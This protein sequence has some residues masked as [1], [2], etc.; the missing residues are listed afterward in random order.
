LIPIEEKKKKKK[1]LAW[2]KSSNRHWGGLEEDDR[3]RV[4]VVADAY[5][6]DDRSRTWLREKGFKYLIAINPTRFKE[7]WMVFKSGGTSNGPVG[8]ELKRRDKGG[9]L[10]VLESKIWEEVHPY[11][12]I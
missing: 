10:S 9:C 2:P 1:G 7:V 12:C 3:K 6:L 8:G 5:Y 11:Q 4:V